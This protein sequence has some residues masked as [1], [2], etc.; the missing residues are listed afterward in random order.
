MTIASNTQ[1]GEVVKQNFK[2]SLFF[3]AIHPENYEMS[4][5]HIESFKE[6][7]T[8]TQKA[9]RGCSQSKFCFKN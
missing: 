4:E 9:E 8:P 3:P 5:M 7:S 2:S 6:L 1:V